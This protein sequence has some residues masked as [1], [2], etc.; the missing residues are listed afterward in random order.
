M[1]IYGIAVGLYLG[2]LAALAWLD[3]R[4][5]KRREVELAAAACWRDP[6]GSS[7]AFRG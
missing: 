2:F 3:S 5:V 4:R 6:S 1:L 7:S